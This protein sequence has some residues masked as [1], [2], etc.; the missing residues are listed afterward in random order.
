MSSKNRPSNSKERQRKLAFLRARYG[1]NCWLCGG[2][3]LFAATRTN[4]RDLATLDH[5]KPVYEGGTHHVLN[6][7]LAHR[8]CNNT[9]RGV[10]DGNPDPIGNAPYRLRLKGRR[11]QVT[12]YWQMFSQLE[13]R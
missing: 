5:V 4:Q 6:L 8:R 7:R 12:R 11:V 1:D 13:A 2:A 9:R 3:M 10:E